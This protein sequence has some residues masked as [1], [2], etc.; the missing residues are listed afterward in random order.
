[1]NTQQGSRNRTRLMSVPA[2]L[3]NLLDVLDSRSRGADATQYRAVVTS[4]AHELTQ[5]DSNAL[6][7]LLRASPAATE[8]YEN[9]QYANAGLCRADLEVAMRAELAA[10]E[11]I[12]RAAKR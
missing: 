2:T 9:Q 10:K 11:A 6:E 12:Q 4:L 1:M 7:A 3:A 5:M 8:I